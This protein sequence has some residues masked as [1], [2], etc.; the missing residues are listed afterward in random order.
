MKEIEI[1][2]LA[3]IC[4]TAL[5]SAALVSD[6]VRRTDDIDSRKREPAR[7]LWPA[8]FVQLFISIFVDSK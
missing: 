8:L 3:A 6:T 4:L 5:L 2:T 1:S 7:V